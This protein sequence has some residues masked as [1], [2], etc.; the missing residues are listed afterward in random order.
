M[1]IILLCAI[2]LITGCVQQSN[3][4]KTPAQ[5]IASVPSP[6][7]TIVQTTPVVTVTPAA[8]PQQAAAYNTYSNSA[9]G[10][11]I[12]YPFDWKVIELSPVNTGQQESQVPSG[13]GPRFDVVV[14]QS[15]PI[16]NCVK[17][18]CVNVVSEVKIEVDPAPF[19]QNLDDYYVKD[20]AWI[21]T[22]NIGNQLAITKRDS[23]FSLSGGKA[24]RLDYHIPVPESNGH[25]YD[26]LNVQRAYTII[27][28][29]AYIITYHAHG[30]ST[31]QYE[32]Y[33]NTVQDMFKSFK[34]QATIKTI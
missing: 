2:I 33:Y 6:A 27:G 18:D 3:T 13:C 29:K 22:I 24:Y 1:I 15:P 21:T 7:D 9:Y 19:T 20:V 5:V 34:A 30:L 31:S 32:T 4:S 26:E 16:N 10:F 11:S 12:N 14:F 17:N 28:G 23:M 25:W 8:A